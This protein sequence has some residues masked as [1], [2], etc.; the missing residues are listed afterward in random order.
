MVSMDKVNIAA[1][2]AAGGSGSRISTQINK[3]YLPLNNKPILIYSFE[4]FALHERIDTIIIV[5][6]RHEMEMCSALI[7]KYNI[8][9]KPTKVVAGGVSRQESVLM[10]L[11]ACDENTDIVLIHDGAR[12]FVTNQM[13]NECLKQMKTYKACSVGV[14]A[15]NTIKQT[16]SEG[17]VS[18]TLNRD[19]LWEVQTPQCFNYQCI[20]ELH[21]KAARASI[22]VTDD[23]SLAEIY[24]IDVKMIKG[25]YD[26]I[27]ITVARDLFTAQGII[28]TK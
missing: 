25:N 18:Q 26:N 7:E 6:A 19:S 20:Y 8:H 9:K 15:I 27:K 10:G 16:D 1:I 21:K 2:I 11:K 17:I 3:Q 12:P 24:N 5:A 14:S 28:K 22:S 4:K 23:C 13:I